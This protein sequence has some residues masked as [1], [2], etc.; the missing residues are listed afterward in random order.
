MD[1]KIVHDLV[2]KVISEDL[3][4]IFSEMLQQSEKRIDDTNKMVRQLADSITKTQELSLSL[5]K[6][7]ENIQS[8]ITDL[9]KANMELTKLME[10]NRED[11][12]ITM[13]GYRDEL[14]SAKGMYRRVSEAYMRM[15]EA[16]ANAS[17]DSS[18]KTDVN[19]TM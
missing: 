19:I 11:F 8:S 3:I 12:R 17:G 2:K 10:L 9:I 15:A 5:I 18:S 16:K 7:A 13:Q 14:Q 4:P 1:K 6:N